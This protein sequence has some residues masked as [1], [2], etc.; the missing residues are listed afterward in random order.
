MRMLNLVVALCQT[1]LHVTDLLPMSKTLVGRCLG[2]NNLSSYDGFLTWTPIKQMR[3]N[4][5]IQPP[6]PKKGSDTGNVVADGL[7]DY[8][9]ELRIETI[10]I[11]NRE[12]QKDLKN[13]ISDLQ[14][15]LEQQKNR[16]CYQAELARVS[17]ISDYFEDVET[18]SNKNFF[19]NNVIENAVLQN[20]LKTEMRNRRKYVQLGNSIEY[21]PIVKRFDVKDITDKNYRSMG[22]SRVAKY[23]VENDIE[24]YNEYSPSG[25][26]N[27]RALRFDFYIPSEDTYIEVQGAQHYRPIDYFGGEESFRRQQICDKIKVQFC[28]DE[29]SALITLR[30]DDMIDEIDVKMVQLIKRWKSKN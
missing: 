26:R 19:I 8:D 10:N 24:F 22:E 15:I 4:G 27:D 23:L 12:A 20:L 29:N 14:R 5:K 21:R 30:Y 28:E 1:I 11:L 18:K 17:G 25:L 9:T 7:Y 13:V 3:Y 16:E 6:H 2:L